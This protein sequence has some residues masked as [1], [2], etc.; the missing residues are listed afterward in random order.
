MT[1]IER[2]TDD[3]KAAMRAG[4]PERTGALR[5]LLAAA[6]NEVIK[7]GHPLSEDETA[8]LLQR[9]AKQRR[10]SITQYEAAARP[11][12]AAVEARELAII[13]EYLPE[14]ATTAE[15]EAWADE[16]IAATGATG[17]AQMGNVIGAV[18]AKA[19]ARADGAAVA[20]VVRRKL[21][22]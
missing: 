9:E 7:A 14:P 2:L 3:M 4:Q 20:A 11:E 1:T 18:V 12:L 5:L 10:D 6:K 8:K 16:A 19:G 21:A 13:A 17:P 15:L 22:G